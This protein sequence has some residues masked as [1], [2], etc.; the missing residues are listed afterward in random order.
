M[1][2]L[3]YKV[4]LCKRCGTKWYWEVFCE[5][6]VVQRSTGKCFV[7][8]LWYKVVLGGTLCKHVSTKYYWEMLVVQSL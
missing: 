3:K 6:I 4:V 2:A 7:Q 8:A 1:Q 5:S